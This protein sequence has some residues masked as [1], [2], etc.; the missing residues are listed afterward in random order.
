M[1]YQLQGKY[2]NQWEDLTAEESFKE[3]KA[4]QREYQEN[5][6]SASGFRIVRRKD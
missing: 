6:R 1:Y 4:R 3:A 5:D 2:A